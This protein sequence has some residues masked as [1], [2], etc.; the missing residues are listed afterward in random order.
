[1]HWS[2]MV[3]FWGEILLKHNPGLDESLLVKALAHLFDLG[4]EITAQRLSDYGYPAPDQP[5]PIPDAPQ[6][7]KIQQVL[8]ESGDQV[9]ITPLVHGYGPLGDFCRRLQIVA[10]SSAHGVWINRYGY[11]SDSKLEAIGEIWN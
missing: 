5:H 3:Q 4:D 2:V 7:R 11:L 6:T 1:M 9:Q 8:A 10:D